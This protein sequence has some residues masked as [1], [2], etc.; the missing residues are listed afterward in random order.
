MRK[1]VER[2]SYWVGVRVVEVVVVG[3]GRGLEGGEERWVGWVVWRGR[4]ALG[5]VLY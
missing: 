1:V 2:V 3:V 4:D 5:L